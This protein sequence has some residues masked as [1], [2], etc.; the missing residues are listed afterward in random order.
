MHT[1]DVSTVQALAQIACGILSPRAMVLPTQT[2]KWCSDL[3]HKISCAQLDAI[4]AGKVPGI[5]DHLFSGRVAVPKL[6]ARIAQLEAEL[7]AAKK[8]LTDAGFNPD[9][10]NAC[11]TAERDAANV[12]A[13]HAEAIAE[14]AYAMLAKFRARMHRVTYTYCARTEDEINMVA[15]H[16]DA[17]RAEKRRE[18]LAQ[19]SAEVATKAT[20]LEEPLPTNDT[21]MVASVV[22]VLPNKR[23]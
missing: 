16:R 5:G 8:S 22:I 7:T 15:E 1:D 10:Y 9:H 6:E 4:R 3:A 17:F 18:L 11:I 12:R 2:M 23:T 13:E 14:G 19:I 20:V 21:I